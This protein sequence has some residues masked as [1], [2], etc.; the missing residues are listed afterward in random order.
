MTVIPKTRQ[1]FSLVEV[2]VAMSIFAFIALGLASAIMQSRRMSEGSIYQT[3]AYGVVYGYSEQIMAMDFMDF[4]LSMEDPT[5]PIVM[6]AISPSSKAGSVDIEDF[7]FLNQWSDKEIVLDV[8]DEGAGERSVIMPMRIRITANRLDTGVDPR[9]AI[10]ITLEYS[11][12]KPV[13]NQS[14]TVNDSIHFVKS[15]VPIY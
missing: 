12:E 13:G 11:F 3:T 15:A 14:V 7:L 10:E 8:R 9:E 4:I 5:L 1:A 6:R 2:I